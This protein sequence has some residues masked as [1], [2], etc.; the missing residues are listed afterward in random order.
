MNSP[1]FEVNGTTIE[2]QT[3]YVQLFVH[4]SRIRSFVNDSLS[5]ASHGATGTKI[6][7]FLR[8]VLVSV[9]IFVSQVMLFSYL[10]PH[11][12]R[13]YLPRSLLEGKQP[14][15]G[16]FS[17]VWPLWDS[18]ADN[19]IHLG[20][21][22]YFFIR[23]LNCL[24]LLFFLCGMLNMIILIPINLSGG[25][26]A[27]GLDRVSITNISSRNV[28]YLNAHFVCALVT[29]AIFLFFANRELSEVAA[30]KQKIMASSA[31]T[32]RLLSRVLLLSNIPKEYRDRAELEALFN[33]FIGHVVGTWFVNDFR[34][35][36]WHHFKAK[37][38]LDLVE[39]MEVGRLTAYLKHLSTGKKLKVRNVQPAI[40]LRLVSL[41]LRFFRFNIKLPLLF[42]KVL[43][44][45]TDGY[46]WARDTLKQANT[47]ISTER[48]RLLK[49]EFE[50][51]GR[52]FIQFD[53]QK[54]AYF[55]HQC[56]LSSDFKKFNHT[57]VNVDPDDILWHNV[58]RDDSVLW[59][60]KKQVVSFVC[61]LTMSSY[62]IPVSFIGMLS[63]VPLMVEL[64]PILSWITF[65]PDEISM[66]LAS[67]LPSLLL[68]L[69]TQVQVVL[70]R[71]MLQHKGK[72]TGAELER[73][74]Q[75]WHFVFLFVQHFL[76]VSILSS[77]MFIMIQVVEK[78]A[79]I[80]LLLAANIPKGA[81]FFY[82][83]FCVKAMTLCGCGLLQFQNLMKRCWVNFRDRT[84]RK[85]YNRCVSLSSVHWGSVY[86][87]FSV[88]GA[89]G[90]T[91]CVISPLMCCFMIF[92]LVLALLTYKYTL[93][94][95]AKPEN[96]SET[97][98]KLYPTA[99]FHLFAGIYCLEICII[100]IL[101]ALTNSEGEYVM[102]YQGLSM[103]CVLA[104]TLYFNVRLKKRF[105][106]HFEYVAAFS[107]HEE[108]SII[109]PER[110][111]SLMYYHPCY[112]YEKPVVWVP[113][114]DHKY[115]EVVVQKYIKD[116]ECFAG[117]SCTGA[118][119]MMEGKVVHMKIE[120]GP[121]R[122]RHYR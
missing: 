81:I 76:V 1:V 80:P 39:T 6:N 113:S 73:D 119:L 118:Q 19:Y 67:F 51:L 56:L 12:P 9:A 29:I 50:K 21:D 30:Y 32:K 95:V 8:H 18:Q 55:A 36:E 72:L 110:E 27:R 54:S 77:L 106:D 101:F 94:H 38:A 5:V 47:Y 99:I 87:V 117:A 115:S 100:G 74:L 53:S 66:L 98:G 111:L 109:Y 85:K 14:K 78:P 68:N 122:S 71:C 7:T 20:L 46:F 65:L 58:L 108:Q 75:R 33:G 70:F 79:S 91:Y 104:L 64:L 90:L 3:S 102:K 89:I 60:V 35:A 88:Y 26:L 96:V 86:P 120:N 45:Q 103:V 62:I 2:R 40:Y 52:A 48:S 31:H 15:Q 10:R 63:R 44:R 42:R 69:L 116:T 83:F 11:F 24:V 112:K 37:D 16:F 105:G 25:H 93:Q 34:E 22:A 17:W 13:L 41:R 84:P 97:F 57:L 23:F 49:G 43:K 28:L 107:R 121:P 61:L 92:F 114:D 4:P 82:K 59:T